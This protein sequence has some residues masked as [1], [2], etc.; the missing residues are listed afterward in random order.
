MAVDPKA[1][2]LKLISEFKARGPQAT[3]ASDCS[4]GNIWLNLC[5]N[6]VAD[7]LENRIYFPNNLSQLNT[8]VCGVAAFVRQWIKDDPV[9]Y[10]WLGIS[11]FENGNG[12]VGRGK[13][14][15]KDL[16]PSKELKSSRVPERK[17][18]DNTITEMNHA[19]WIVMASIREAFNDVFD[20]SANEGIFAI[21]AW[22]FPS[23]VVATFKAAGYSNIV[24]DTDWGNTQG[25]VSLQE[26]S[27]KFQDKWRVV[28]LI[29]TRM[30]D[31]AKLD[32]QAAFPTS[33]HWI[34][35]QSAIPVTLAGSEYRVS[36]FKVFTWGKERMV[37]E[38]L[39]SVSLEAFLK[40]Y[41]GY[42]A[43]KY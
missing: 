42:I 22:N 38:K 26:A 43:A 14:H 16:R 21:R 15:G 40:N 19:D 41:Y 31:D 10:A 39:T 33:D 18:K 30:L 4:K 23:E 11:L 13:Y 1:H 32:T 9:G 24:D 36:K 5:R 7:G 37:P 3:K 20:Y 8:N 2:A 17:N 29:N 6:K 35:L 25:I 12:Y 34:G 27:R 28:L